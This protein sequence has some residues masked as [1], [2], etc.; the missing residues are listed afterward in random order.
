MK[1]TEHKYVRL[2][3]VLISAEGNL[4]DGG[5]TMKRMRILCSSSKCVHRR[6][7]GYYGI[8]RHP[9]SNQIIPYAGITRIYAETCDLMERER[10][11]KKKKGGLK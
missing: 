5:D 11:Y 10:A 9:T 7:N 3:L 4:F 6:G 2:P 8:C 1:D